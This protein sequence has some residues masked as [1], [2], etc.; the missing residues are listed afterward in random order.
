MTS[1]R[2]LVDPTKFAVELM[3]ILEAA[4]SRE[5][6]VLAIIYFASSPRNGFH[7]VGKRYLRARELPGPLLEQGAAQRER[8]SDF[9]SGRGH[10]LRS[11]P[12]LPLPPRR[13]VSY[14]RH[15]IPV[16]WQRVLTHENP[17][18]SVVKKNVP[19]VANGAVA[20]GD[21]IETRLSRRTVPA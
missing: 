5:R 16:R 17:Q 1:I 2:V 11:V 13:D 10:L 7:H 8:S 9:G 21:N 14:S 3:K 15:F 12:T 4:Y 20:S 6:S 19:L 18:G